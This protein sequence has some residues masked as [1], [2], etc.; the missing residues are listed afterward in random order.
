MTRS[1]CTELHGVLL[2]CLQTDP[3]D[4]VACPL[5]A[6]DSLEAG[7]PQTRCLGLLPSDLLISSRIGSIIFSPERCCYMHIPTTARLEA[8]RYR[9]RRYYAGSNRMTA[10]L[11]GCTRYDEKPGRARS[12][13]PAPL[14]LAP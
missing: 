13:T 12:P 5:V 10:G 3:S 1:Q 11:A 9:F 6:A 7:V 2:A 14:S 8:I 4:R